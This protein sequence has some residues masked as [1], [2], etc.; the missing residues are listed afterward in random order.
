MFVVHC[1]GL[2]EKKKEKANN[3]T[4]DGAGGEGCSDHDFETLNEDRKPASS[5]PRAASSIN[6]QHFD[7]ARLLVYLSRSFLQNKENGFDKKKRT[8]RMKRFCATI[9]SRRHLFPLIRPF[10]RYKCVRACV[11]VCVCVYVYVCVNFRFYNYIIIYL[12]IWR[13]LKLQRRYIK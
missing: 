3:V 5:P 11:C 2:L 6:R 10:L 1:S 9:I 8:E 12:L 13:E 4:H 7:I